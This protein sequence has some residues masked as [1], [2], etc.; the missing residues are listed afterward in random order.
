MRGGGKGRPERERRAEKGKEKGM[1]EGRVRGGTGCT[2]ECKRTFIWERCAKPPLSMI[3][4]SDFEAVPDVFD[5]KG[6]PGVKVVVG[7]HCPNW[8]T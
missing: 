5:E 8:T 6:T 7:Q 3:K 2:S 4:Q 1:T